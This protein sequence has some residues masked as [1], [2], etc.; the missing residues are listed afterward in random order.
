MRQA[1]GRSVNRVDGRDKVRGLAR[2]AADHRLAGLAHAVLVQSEVPRGTLDPAG[3]EQV[4]RRVEELPG[5]L[6][7]LYPGNCPPLHAPPAEL[8]DDLPVE[9]RPPLADWVI[10]HVGQHLAL[11]VAETLEEATAAAAALRFVPARGEARTDF[12]AADAPAARDEP[13]TGCVRVGA[14]FPDHFVKLAGEKL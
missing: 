3:A 13:E 5:V 11:V 2:F 14:Y 4:V 9:R 6:H 1:A 12:L 8:T 10:H 7:V